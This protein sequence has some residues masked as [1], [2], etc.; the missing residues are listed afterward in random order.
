MKII[1]KIFTAA[2]LVVSVIQS[3]KE[4][5][6]EILHD[7]SAAPGPI[8]DPVAEAIPGGAIIRYGLPADENLLYVK[9]VYE[10]GGKEVV[11][12]SSLYN[13]QVL[14]EGLGDTQEREVTLYAVSRSEVEST[15]VMIRITPLTPTIEDVLESLDIVESFGGMR[16]TFENKAST[17]E[18][19]SN[20]VIG[21][22]RWNDELKEWEDIDAHYTGL[23]QG[24]FSV[25]GLD[26]VKGTFGFYVK[27]V[28]DNQSDTIS[29]E[30]TPIYEEELIGTTFRDMRSGSPQYPIPQIPPLPASG[31][32]I[33][34]PGNLGSWPWARL[35]DGELGN[36][37]FH[38]TER[39]DVPIWIPIDMRVK[40][41]LSRY[42]IWQRNSNGGYLYSH[43]NP[44][45]WEIWG[46]NTPEDV[47]SWERLDHRVME[48]PSGLP[49]G[50]LSNDDLAIAEAGHEYEFSIDAPPVRYI[51][52]KHIDSWASIEGATGFLHMAEMKI[53]GQIQ[54]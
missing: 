46:T 16:V 17:P 52:W 49:L 35:W 14:V 7:D 23:A 13:D 50:Q 19:P 32:P 21:V 51:A 10:R 1:L 42:R 6:N 27:D 22:V 34:H 5:T 37:G 2:L 39:M 11:S 43:G 36:T 12:K 44:H 53:W 28:W 48:K 24:D 8:S 18:T 26:A 30:L 25:R 31:E 3:C 4:E 54:E 47:D 15:P 41:K 45:E 29:T 38:T 33:K 9:A 40:V 20:I